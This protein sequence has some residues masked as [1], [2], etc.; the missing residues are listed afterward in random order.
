[1]FVNGKIEIVALSERY[2]DSKLSF[3]EY[4]LKNYGNNAQNSIIKSEKS[5]VYI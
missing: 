4:V 5:N 1:M 3:K 2:K